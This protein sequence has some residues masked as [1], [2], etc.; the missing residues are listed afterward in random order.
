[1]PNAFSNYIYQQKPSTIIYMKSYKKP[2]FTMQHTQLDKRKTYL[3]VIFAIKIFKLVRFFFHLSYNSINRELLSSKIVFWGGKSSVLWSEISFC[4]DEIC[5][6][7]TDDLPRQ[8]TIISRVIPI[9]FHIF[10]F[11]TH[12]LPKTS[13]ISDVK[14][15]SDVT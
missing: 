15:K 10:H 5:D 7:K 3:S 14:P 2:S 8:M 13:G 6:H 4:G 9:L 1:M 11:K 12:Y